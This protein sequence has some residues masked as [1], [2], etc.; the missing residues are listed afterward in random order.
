MLVSI[1]PCQIDFL[2]IFLASLQRQS[3]AAV[4]NQLAEYY[5]LHQEIHSAPILEDYVRNADK[6]CSIITGSKSNLKSICIYVLFDIM[7]L[8]CFCAACFL[9][10]IKL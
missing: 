1:F 5:K 6:A 3:S 8:G 10:Y 9:Q 7:V 4:V 2:I